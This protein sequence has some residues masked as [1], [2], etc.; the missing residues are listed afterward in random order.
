MPHH[1]GHQSLPP[2]NDLAYGHTYRNNP[3][4]LLGGLNFP[5]SD[6]QQQHN[7]I[8]NKLNGLSINRGNQPS[9]FMGNQQSS[10]ATSGLGLNLPTFQMV[11][12]GLQGLGNIAAGWAALK[13]SR[14]AEEELK[15][16][17]DLAN[18]NYDMSLQAYNDN[19][20]M[21]D[22][23]QQERQSFVNST[24]AD[25]SKSNIQTLRN[26]QLAPA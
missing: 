9:T 21:Y 12:S 5:Y 24:H 4:D 11:G 8:F 14:I 20:R 15:F 19:V 26:Y 10:S 25:P 1:P 13:N 22:I 17:K 6:G 3:N 2:R 7:D 16:N 18:K 23:G